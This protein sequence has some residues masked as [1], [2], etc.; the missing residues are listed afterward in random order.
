MTRII[1]VYAGQPDM[2]VIQAPYIIT[3][4]LY[5]FL[6]KHAEVVYYPWVSTDDPDVREDDIIL[7]HPNYDPN[8]VIQRAFQKPCKAK[9][10]IHP[11]H[12]NRILDNRPFDHLVGISD[13]LFAICGEYWIDSIDSTVFAHWKPKITRVDLA[14]DPQTYPYLKHSFNGP[15][16]R[17]LVY[18][19]S[20]SP[21]KNLGYLRRIML[22]LPQ[23]TLHWY[24]GDS[25]HPLAKLPNV[26]T[27][28]WVFLDAAMGKEICKWC[29]IKI[30]VSDS[31]ANPT[32]LLESSAWGLIPACTRESGYYNDP[33]FTELFL[34]DESRTVEILK[35]LLAI[36][37]SV[38]HERSLQNR[39][40]IES[41]YTWT[42]FC[43]TI[44]DTISGYL[45]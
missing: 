18:I 4:K 31:D 7:G 6:A 13:R 23:V 35:E 17:R 12:T 41:K 38:L 21:N 1:F 32:T 43:N 3:N 11:F 15:G 2:G 42:R 40:I 39:E 26:R 19:G 29:D 8:T 34:D 33:M 30:S 9:F 27:T 45:E 37:S 16:N 24:G 20:S 28:G 44:W 10:L 36:D 14:V 22:R 5:H 25:E